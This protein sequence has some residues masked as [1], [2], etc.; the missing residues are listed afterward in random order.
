MVRFFSKIYT[1]MYIICVIA[2]TKSSY[3]YMYVLYV[4]INLSY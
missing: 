4:A 1:F 3:N 2:M